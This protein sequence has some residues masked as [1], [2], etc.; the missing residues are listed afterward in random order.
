MIEAAR[1]AHDAIRVDAA[2]QAWVLGHQ[3]PLAERVFLWITILGGITGMRVL[4]LLGAVYLWYRGRRRVSAVTLIAAVL[5]DA[6]FH[7]AKRV[8]ARPRPQ[9]LGGRVDADFSF[10]SGHSTVSAAVCCT[11]AYA[12]WREGFIGRGKA[13]TLAVAA[14]LLVGFSRVYLNVHWATDVI[15]GWCFGILIAILSI[16]LYERLR[17]PAANR[18]SGLSP[19]RAST[20]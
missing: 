6:L 20:P 3:L 5:G 8:Y 10:P 18:A 7:V 16:V 13:I 19:S 1:L 9:G 12:L 2:V 17:P 11:L 15:G 14:P 4:A